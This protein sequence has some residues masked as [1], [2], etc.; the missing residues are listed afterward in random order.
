[1]IEN[2]S[3][4]GRAAVDMLKTFIQSTAGTALLEEQALKLV[5]LPQDQTDEGIA[6]VCRELAKCFA[7][8][9][10]LSRPCTH[11]FGPPDCV[12]GSPLSLQ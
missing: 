8:D 12:A 6:A 4:D 10:R 11:K 2:F 1:M 7:Q 9:G 3:P 5:G